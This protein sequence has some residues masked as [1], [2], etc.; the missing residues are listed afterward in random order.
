MRV[1]VSNLCSVVFLFGSFVMIVYLTK[2]EE[3]RNEVGDALM[4][5]VFAISI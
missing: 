5:L 3:D 2:S 4:S 1:F